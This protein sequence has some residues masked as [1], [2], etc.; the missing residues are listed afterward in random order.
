[1]AGKS[2]RFVGLRLLK[3]ALVSQIATILTSQAKLY[4]RFLASAPRQ[5]KT[6]HF[7]RAPFYRKSVSRAEK[8]NEALK[9]LIKLTEKV[10]N[11]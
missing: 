7:S 6:T 2:F 1:M 4:P 3:K 11:Q 8:G 5:R 10:L 9:N